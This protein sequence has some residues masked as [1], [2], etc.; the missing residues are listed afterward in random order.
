MC[1][2]YNDDDERRVVAERFVESGIQ[3]GEEVHYLCHTL[4]GE[5][6]DAAQQRVGIKPVPDAKRC[7][8]R[9]A[10]ALATYCPDHTFV[11]QRMLDTVREMYLTGIRNG[12][13]GVRAT[14]EMAWALEGLPGTGRLIEYESLLNNVVAE[15]PCTALCQYDARRFDGATLFH[16]LTVHPAMVVRGQVVRNPYYIP[17]EVFLAK[18]RAAE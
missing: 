16:V 9:F 2:I 8:L 4:P 13:P 10:Q 17:P 12:F 11:T 18:L 6:L 1:Y 5:S 14:G 15:Y 7:L 3:G